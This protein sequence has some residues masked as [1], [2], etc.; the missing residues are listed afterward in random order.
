MNTHK[1]DPSMRYRRTGANIYLNFVFNT[2]PQ[3]QPGAQWFTMR[4]ERSTDAIGALLPRELTDGERTFQIG[5]V[6]RQI[7]VEPDPFSADCWQISLTVGRNSPYRIVRHTRQANGEVLEE[8]AFPLP[9]EPQEAEP[10]TLL[11]TGA[12]L[13]KHP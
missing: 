6:R 13:S 10:A 1:T 9:S 7:S 5:G 2:L 3:D 11:R 8:V 12:S 4:L